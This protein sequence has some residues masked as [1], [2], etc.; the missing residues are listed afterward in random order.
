MW[1]ISFTS[2]EIVFLSAFMMLD[3]ALLMLLH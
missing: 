2:V 1:S 3:M